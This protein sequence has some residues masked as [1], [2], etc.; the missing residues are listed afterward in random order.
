MGLSVPVLA[1]PQRVINSITIYLPNAEGLTVT[2][3]NVHD[4]YSQHPAYVFD[5]N[6]FILEPSGTIS[7]NRDVTLAI[8]EAMDSVELRAGEVF[9]F[10]GH[11]SG[12]VIELVRLRSDFASDRNFDFSFWTHT[13]FPG[14]DAL[15]RSQNWN[16]SPWTWLP[17]SGLTTQATTPPT[18]NNNRFFVGRIFGTSFYFDS[19]PLE[20]DL[21]GGEWRDEAV[22]TIA[23]GT[24]LIVE[25]E[26][27]IN[28]DW[29]PWTVTTN[30]RQG[31][32]V[33]WVRQGNRSGQITFNNAGLFVACG[34]KDGAFYVLV[35]DNV[36]TATP[37]PAPTQTPS[38]TPP[39]A[40]ASI[41]Q[42][43]AP[44]SSIDTG[45]WMEFTTVPNNRFGYR[46]FRA[47]SATGEGISITDFPIMVNPAHSLNRIITFDPN[48][49]PN[50]DYWFY[51]REV[52][53]EARF[54]AST[55]TLIPEVLGP[56]SARVHVRTSGA[57]TETVA[58]RGFIMMFIG[59]P[60]MNVNNVWEG[61]DPPANNT[62]PL[63]NAGRTM[64]PIRAIIEAMGG[65]ADWN[66]SLR[67][68]DLRSHGNHVQ[69]WLGER[70]VGVNGV[71]A[72][73]DV[74]PQVING[75]TLIPLRFVAEFLGQQVEWI[76]S[77]QMIVIVYEL[78]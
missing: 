67:R 13:N 2:M 51:I 49:R 60:F 31:N 48:L 52:I 21:S 57:I 27:V 8:P 56:P 58:E 14:V 20:T 34:E 45:V 65:R 43:V 1:R 78:Q 37:T 18:G 6:N 33:P 76:G 63:I 24:S 22:Y 66:S 59:N 73:M 11:I 12:H 61:I 26:E 30:N 28:W 25:S 36:P 44:P 77:Q 5:G 55:T 16:Q 29:M 23:R 32:I 75:R 40:N 4:H 46:V 42:F 41:P 10:N 54:D 19:T 3:T 15:I 50:R 72:E 38:P 7:F 62:A 69:M 39:P 70:N 17:L 35:V 64:V 74:V 9:A 71:T 68:I 53:E 47:T